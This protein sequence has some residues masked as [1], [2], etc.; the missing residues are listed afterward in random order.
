M[1]IPPEEVISIVIRHGAMVCYALLH[2][3]MDLKVG[4]AVSDLRPTQMQ[5]NNDTSPR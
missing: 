5:S 4:R 3:H 1:M 2:A